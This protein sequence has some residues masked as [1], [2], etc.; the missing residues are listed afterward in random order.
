[1]INKLIGSKQ[2]KNKYN[3]YKEKRKEKNK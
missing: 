3:K 2:E 1:L